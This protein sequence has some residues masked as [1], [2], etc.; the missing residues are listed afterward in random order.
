MNIVSRLRRA[1]TNLAFGGSLLKGS[2]NEDKDISISLEDSN[3]PNV[4]KHFEDLMTTID[5]DK[6][7]PV[8][9]ANDENLGFGGPIG[10]GFNW[11][12][13]E[14][15]LVYVEGYPLMVILD[16]RR[17]ATNWALCTRG[18]EYTRQGLT[19]PI[20]LKRGVNGVP[21]AKVPKHMLEELG[22]SIY[23]GEKIKLKTIDHT[24][25]VIDFLKTDQGITYVFKDE[26]GNKL[27][28]SS[29]K[30]EELNK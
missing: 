25:T 15:S 22:I 19:Q 17:G 10:D 27:T 8:T 7:F 1:A 9:D 2:L 23:Y 21:I 26:N 5:E 20:I 13:V 4:H 30:F 14:D 3:N 28:I 29:Q 18:Y 12:P 6:L 16:I 24:L 11:G